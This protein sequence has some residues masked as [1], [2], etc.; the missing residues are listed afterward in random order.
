MRTKKILFS[1]LSVILALSFILSLSSCD[2]FGKDDNGDSQDS[3]SENS[4]PKDIILFGGETDNYRIVYS[5][6]VTNTLRTSIQKLKT[7]LEAITGKTV[8]VAS[9]TSAAN[10]ETA[11]EIIIGRTQRAQNEK[12]I[13]ALDGVGY[14]YSAIDEKLMI[15]GTNDYLTAKAV[16]ELVSKLRIEG[17]KITAPAEMLGFTD[18]SAEMIKLVGDDGKFTYDVIV[19]RDKYTLGS[20]FKSKVEKLLSKDGA[21]VKVTVKYDD[22]VPETAGAQEILIGKTNRAASTR[23]YSEIGY[24]AYRLFNEG[25]SILIGSYKDDFLTTAINMLYDYI[26]EAYDSSADGNCYI[27]KNF[28]IK[29]EAY[30]WTNELPLLKGAAFEGIY[31]PK[32]GTYVLDYTDV[33]SESI[34]TDYISTLTAKGFKLEKSYELGENKYALLYGEEMNTYV[35]YIKNTGEIRIF[36]EKSGTLYPTASTSYTEGSITPT[37]YQLR[38]DNYGSRENGGMSYVIQMS[39]GS[40]IIIDGGYNT[41]EE[42]D[43]LY[44]F[45]KSKTPDGQKPVIEAWY[46]THLHGDHYGAFLAFASKYGSTHVDLKG[47]YWN[48]LLG[49]AEHMNDTSNFSSSVVSSLRKAAESYAGAKLYEKIHTGMTMDFGGAQVKVM[50]THEDVYPAKMVDGNDTST[51]LRVDVGGQRMIFLGDC[52][53]SESSAML[54]NFGENSTELS[55]DIVQWSHHG[56]EGATKALYQKIGAHTVLLPLNVVGWQTLNYEEGNTDPNPESIVNNW[57]NNTGLPCGD[58]LKTNTTVKNIVIA[59]VADNYYCDTCIGVN[60]GGH[61]GA[62]QALPL[63]YTQDTGKT[64]QALIN[65][66]ISQANSYYNAHKNDRAKHIAE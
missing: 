63:P 10:K 53:D 4:T 1:I 8:T 20:S 17:K 51:V 5:T 58:Y 61:C 9:D 57:L 45:L 31:D 43:H 29:D 48:F 41:E 22:V 7:E 14:T 15:I 6:S 66:C 38:V 36:L 33:A 35:S 50:C 11:K 62:Y 3:T 42:A 39:N 32:D 37:L 25:E 18:C 30:G 24:F 52:R 56:Y 21:K 47:V 27:P 26:K 54:R 59:G 34:Y 44:K 46:I 19:S 12:A 40:F 23:L 64:G 2:N 60:S 13:S 28:D 65:D 55:A 16:D 49:N